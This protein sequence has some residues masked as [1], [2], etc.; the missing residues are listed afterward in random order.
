MVFGCFS[1]FG[2]DN[3]RNLR[4]ESLPSTP[5]HGISKLDLRPRFSA[6]QSH[7]FYS[8]RIQKYAN[9]ARK[10]ESLDPRRTGG[11]LQDAGTCSLRKNGCTT[12]RP[13]F[14]KHFPF[15]LRCFNW[16]RLALWTMWPSSWLHKVCTA[17]A[18]QSSQ[19]PVIQDRFDS[20]S[21]FLGATILGVNFGN[22]WVI[23]PHVYM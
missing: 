12:L 1:C 5:C 2:K 20:L 10:T 8:E 15:R 14:P 22:T 23:G 6:G 7:P 19:P 9:D 4:V 16:Q 21:W 13:S 17:C 18:T 3:S 11:L